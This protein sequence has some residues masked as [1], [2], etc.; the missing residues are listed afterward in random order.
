MFDFLRQKSNATADMVAEALFNVLIGP[1]ESEAEWMATFNDLEIDPDCGLSELFYLRAAA[2]DIAVVTALE[3]DPGQEDVLSGYRA[4]LEKLLE[5]RYSRED[6]ESRKVAYLEAFKRSV[7]EGAGKVSEGKS[8]PY[9]D[10][11]LKFAQFCG[12]EDIALVPI[13]G[14]FAAYLNNTHEFLRSIKIVE[15]GFGGSQ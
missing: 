8:N 4:R 14:N 13:G 15:S 3:A 10:I 9:M 6:F 11:A 7:L 1:S 12:S 2:V 5:E